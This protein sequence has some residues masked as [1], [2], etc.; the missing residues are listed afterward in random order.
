MLPKLSRRSATTSPA[1][2]ASSSAGTA[3][4]IAAS[5]WR[6]TTGPRGSR[7]SR[8]SVA[9]FFPLFFLVAAPLKWSSQ[10][11]QKRFLRVSRLAGDQWVCVTNALG[12]CSEMFGS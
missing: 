10:T 5:L 12:R 6:T 11:S 3:G 1:N 7:L 8:G 9:P 4:W 2:A